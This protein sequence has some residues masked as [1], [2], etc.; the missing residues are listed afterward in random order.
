MTTQNESVKFEELVSHVLQSIVQFPEALEIKSRTQAQGGAQISAKVHPD[1]VG[2]VIGK[3]GSTITAI[4]AV[5]EFAARRQ[6]ENASFDIEN[7]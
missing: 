3:G 2:R 6:G 5:L 4:R 1:D 7:A